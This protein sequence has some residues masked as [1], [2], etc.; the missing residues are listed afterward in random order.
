MSIRN[1]GTWVLATVLSAF[2][3]WAVVAAYLGWSIG[4]EAEMPSI[5]Y[6]ALAFGVVLSL[7]V[8]IGLMALVFY[9][10]RAGYDEPPTYVTRNGPTNS[11]EDDPDGAA[12]D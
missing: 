5:G 1:L 3:T 2:L 7:I 10:S 6:A 12:R 11:A 4:G 9:S 8:G